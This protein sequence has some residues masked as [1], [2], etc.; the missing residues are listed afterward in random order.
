[1]ALKSRLILYFAPQEIV[2]EFHGAIKYYV[3][4]HQ[5]MSMKRTCMLTPDQQTIQTQD[6]ELF[7]E[8]FIL[9]SSQVK[10]HMC[11]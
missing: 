6:D 4:N 1:M 10:T 8:A 11:L 5:Y 3:E 7:Y 2:S 9:L